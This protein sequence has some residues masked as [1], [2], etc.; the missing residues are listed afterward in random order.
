MI[1]LVLPLVRV[2]S[3]SQCTQASLGPTYLKNENSGKKDEEDRHPGYREVQVFWSASTR[4]VKGLLKWLQ[5][6]KK[7]KQQLRTSLAF[8]G[9]ISRQ[10]SYPRS[11]LKPSILRTL[12]KPA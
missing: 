6:K 8:L 4:D 7:K 3:S 12:E 2:Q 11:K 5:E 9:I 1:V 10:F